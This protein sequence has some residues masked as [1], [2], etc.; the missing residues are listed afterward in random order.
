MVTQQQI[1]FGLLNRI[2]GGFTSNYMP[3][4]LEQM[5]FHINA[6]R[7]KI[8]T[9]RINKNPGNAYS[10]KLA[11]DLGA[12]P[13]TCV[14]RAD[15]CF[16]MWGQ[17]VYKVPLPNMIITDQ[18]SGTTFIGLLDKSTKIEEYDNQQM[19]YLKYRRYTSNKRYCYRTN[20]YLYILNGTNPPLTHINIQ[21]VLADPKDINNYL[22]PDDICFDENSEYPVD[23]AWI[24]PIEKLILINVLIP[25]V[26]SNPDFTA[27]ANAI[28]NGLNGIKQENI[29]VASDQEQ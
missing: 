25:L 12:V 24:T 2:F 9:E 27:N 28:L 3:I 5:Y 17:N 19:N 7:A 18:F 8:A 16:G 13:I 4:S 11:Q 23:P 1:T 21:A 20:T 15:S 22:C 10:F 14:D 6:F 26:A 29:P